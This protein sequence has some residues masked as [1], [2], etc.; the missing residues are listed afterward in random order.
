MFSRQAALEV[1]ARGFCLC[2]G[3]L[4]P[5]NPQPARGLQASIA[6]RDVSKSLPSLPAGD[7]GAVPYSFP[8]LTRPEVTPPDIGMMMDADD[9]FSAAHPDRDYLLRLARPDE[10]VA[11]DPPPPAGH[12]V[13]LVTTRYVRGFAIFET[14]NAP[15]IGELED[16]D[17]ARELWQGLL[18]MA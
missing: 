9:A 6:G 15:A 5:C 17:V 8:R 13:Y 1:A 11:L 14:P 18:A 12:F 10:I 7:R 16:E 3:R 2:H 4:L